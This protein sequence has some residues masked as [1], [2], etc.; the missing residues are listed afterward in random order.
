MTDINTLVRSIGGAGSTRL[1]ICV[2]ILLQ[3]MPGSST[4]VR[5]TG[6]AGNNTN[7]IVGAGGDRRK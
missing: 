6:G 1:V 4:V 5:S 7:G 3:N 2:K